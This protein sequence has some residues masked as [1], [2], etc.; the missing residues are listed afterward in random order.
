MSNES[1]IMLHRGGARGETRRVRRWTAD[2]V[3]SH[4]VL[5]ET[6]LMLS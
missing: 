1:G 3:E 6:K 4:F 5:L 2:A